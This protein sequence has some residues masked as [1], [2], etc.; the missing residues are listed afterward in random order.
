M[1]DRIDLRIDSDLKRKFKEKADAE[2]GGMSRFLQLVI[3]S[4]VD[5]DGFACDEELTSLL[6]AVRALNSFTNNVNQ[7]TKRMHSE[8][9]IPSERTLQELAELK[10]YSSDAA[11]AFRACLDRR[12]IALESLS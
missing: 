3:E 9:R 10:S 12:N 5:D 6:Y 4:Y 8:G 11:D 1:K 2:Y 7:I